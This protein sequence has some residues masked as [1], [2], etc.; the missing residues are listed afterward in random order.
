M[1][2]GQRPAA[3]H[4]LLWAGAAKVNQG[5]PPLVKDPR[6]VKRTA[7]SPRLLLPTAFCS[8]ARPK[9]FG[10]EAP[11]KKS[12]TARI[13]QENRMNSRSRRR[14]RQL[15]ARRPALEPEAQGHPG[16]VKVGP[17]HVDQAHLEGGE[18]NEFFIR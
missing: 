16:G 3:R 6:L 2:E 14:A 1:S 9:Q 18:S 11:V 5:D 17:F 12:K 10:M 7:D 13:S 8:V 15:G 4:E